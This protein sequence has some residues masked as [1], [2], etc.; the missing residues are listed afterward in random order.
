MM[1]RLRFT[2][3]LQPA[4]KDGHVGQGRKHILFPTPVEN[5]FF[6]SEEVVG[7]KERNFWAG[8]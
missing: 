8:W 6:S 1:M 5:R 3:K 7:R 2:R 4:E